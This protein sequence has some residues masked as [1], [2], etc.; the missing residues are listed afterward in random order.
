[1]KSA[2]LAVFWGDTRTLL[3][4]DEKKDALA[5]AT[6][7]SIS[8]DEILLRDVATNRL[9]VITEKNQKNLFCDLCKNELIR[10]R[11]GK[12]CPDF[13]KCALQGEHRGKSNGT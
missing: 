4:E 5:H 9:I 6:L 12:T 13:A 2:K 1:V 3:S 11:Y 7:E 8:G 10:E